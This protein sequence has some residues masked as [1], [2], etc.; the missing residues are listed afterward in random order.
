MAKEL[1]GFIECVVEEHSRVKKTE[2]DGLDLE[3]ILLQI[4]RL[5]TIGFSIHRDSVKTIILVIINYAFHF[6][7]FDL[8]KF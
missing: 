8:G 4:Q 7:R 6:G 3:D 2:A 1:D 5:H